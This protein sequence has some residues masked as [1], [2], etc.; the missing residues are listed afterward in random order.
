MFQDSLSSGDQITTLVVS[1]LGGG[2][3]SSSAVISTEE[4]EQV[5]DVRGTRSRGLL[6][7]VLGK[8]KGDTTVEPQRGFSRS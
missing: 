5:C 6:L 2:I 4:Q 8:Q 3:S 1:L 7:A